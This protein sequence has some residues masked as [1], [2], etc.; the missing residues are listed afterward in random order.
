[1]RWFW[2]IVLIA[3]ALPAAVPRKTH[4]SKPTPRLY[5]ER[6]PV[7]LLRT[8]NSKVRQKIVD[9]HN[10]LRTQVKPPAANMLAMKWHPGLA[11]A[12]QRWAN[13]CLGLVHDNAT[14]LYLDGFG[15]SGQNIF[16]TTRRTLWNFPIR[17]WYMEYKDYKYGDDE[18]NDLHEIGH[19]TQIAWA[20]THLVGCGVSHCTGGR[21]PLGKD[22]F[23]YVCNYA[24]SGNYK[25]RLGHP[26]VAGKPCTMC[27]DHCSR[28]K[29]CTN[30]CHYVDLWSN[31]VEL[32]RMFRSWVC[33]TNTSEGRERRKFC[34]A[35]CNCEGKIYYHHG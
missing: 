12:A 5:G 25:G 6:V 16:I 32:A 33:E 10:Y 17:M 22:F 34:G 2:I 20:T 1:M 4:R 3:L 35:T 13:R 19:Y 23:M 31:C 21:G 8:S 14:G 28:N 24:P 27:K 26:Y 7:K 29:L 11:K 9:T 18:G 30:A 15:Q